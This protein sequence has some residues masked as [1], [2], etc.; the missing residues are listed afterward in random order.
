MMKDFLYIPK[1]LD[2]QEETQLIEQIYSNCDSQESDDWQHVNKRRI[3][4]FGL[5]Y[6][7]PTF[8]VIRDQVPAFPQFIDRILN[9]KIYPALDEYY[10]TRQTPLD[11]VDS[12]LPEGYL[13]YPVGS[14]TYFNQLTI[15]EYQPKAGIPAHVD[16]CDYFGDFILVITLQSHTVMH[17]EEAG[18]PPAPPVPMKKNL[19]QALYHDFIK[20]QKQQVLDRTAFDRPTRLKTTPAADVKVGGK[21]DENIMSVLTGKTGRTVK[22]SGQQN[23]YPTYEG[24][25]N[26]LLDRGSLA[27][28]FGDSRYLFKH[29]IRDRST[30]LLSMCDNYENTCNDGGTT[31]K[32][33]S[34][35]ND[36]VKEEIQKRG[37]RI[38]LTFRHAKLSYHGKVQ[39]EPIIHYHKYD[40]CELG[41]K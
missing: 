31:N 32:Q 8:S 41:G 3:K 2:S 14:R 40:G 26:M 30:D 21:V 18:W 19:N 25:L 36:D 11:T 1:F 13:Q 28:M 37:V 12:R 39:R 34:Q 35:N 23:R 15:Q 6:D 4:H 7:Y 17:F 20:Q 27:I 33:D 9:E 38:S 16:I 22:A 24:M 10:S 5:E 29:S